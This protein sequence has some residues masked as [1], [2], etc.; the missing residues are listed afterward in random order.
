LT[1]SG[2]L[3]VDILGTGIELTIGGVLANTGSV[4][5]GTLGEGLNAT[6]VTA[7]GL[8]NTGSVNVGAYSGPGATLNVTGAAPSTATG[9]TLIAGDGLIDFASGGITAIGAGASFEM[10]GA[11]ARASI[12]AGRPPNRR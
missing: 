2:T 7:R 1:H 10:Y 3:D 5:I 11:G 8:V 9:S 6:T 12:G 4:N